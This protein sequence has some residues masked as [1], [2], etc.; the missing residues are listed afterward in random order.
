MFLPKLFAR[1]KGWKAFHEEGFMTWPVSNHHHQGLSWSAHVCLNHFCIFISTSS[2]LSLS[3]SGN[4]GVSTNTTFFEEPSNWIVHRTCSTLVVQ[5]SSPSLTLSR[6]FPAAVL[7]NFFFLIL[8]RDVRICLLPIPTGTHRALPYSRWPDNANDNRR[9]GKRKLNSSDRYPGY[10]R[11]TQWLYPLT[12][13][14]PIESVLRRDDPFKFG[15]FRRKSQSF[16]QSC[17]EDPGTRRICMVFS[18][19]PLFVYAN[20]LQIPLSKFIDS[21]F[22]PDHKWIRDAG[23]G[24]IA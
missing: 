2:T 1:K 12:I 6:G 8:I 14:P 15:L 18:L 9:K 4:A 10:F 22:R 11:R 13:C 17:G 7:M 3:G 5:G 24:D 19:C 21:R 23:R 20:Q 16:R